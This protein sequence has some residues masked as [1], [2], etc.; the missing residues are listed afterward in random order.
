[1]VLLSLYFFGKGEKLEI[2]NG[3]DVQ[4]LGKGKQTFGLMVLGINWDT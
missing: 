4:K 3:T 1:M 2:I